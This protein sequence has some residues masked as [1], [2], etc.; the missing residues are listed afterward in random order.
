[1]KLRRE[2]QSRAMKQHQPG[3]EEREAEHLAASQVSHQCLSVYGPQ[4]VCPSR[5]PAGFCCALCLLPS[6]V[7]MFSN[8]VSF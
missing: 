7:F 1:M 2:D 5:L 4:P 6:P 8:Y 3:P